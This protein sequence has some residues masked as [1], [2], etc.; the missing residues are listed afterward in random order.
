MY[1]DE[2]D[3]TYEFEIGA[4]FRRMMEQ[5]IARLESDAAN[6]EAMLQH[7]KNRDHIRRQMRLVAM[8]REDAQRIRRF[9]TQSGTREPGPMMAL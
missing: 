1:G 7:L 4:R 5:R 3:S 2:T 6:D 8:Q 9:L